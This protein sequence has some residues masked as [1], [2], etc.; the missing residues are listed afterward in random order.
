MDPQGG[1]ARPPAQHYLP[2]QCGLQQ[3][4][5][6]SLHCSSCLLPPASCQDYPCLPRSSLLQL[7]T[8]PHGHSWS[9]TIALFGDMVSSPRLETGD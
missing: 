5:V 4:L 9:P 8:L 3:G 7:R 1:G 6:H 2:L